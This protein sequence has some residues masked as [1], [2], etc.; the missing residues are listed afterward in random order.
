[1]NPSLTIGSTTVGHDSPCYIIG[2]IGL[3]HNGDL[4]IAK[5]LIDV[6]AFAGCDA[7]KFQKRDP[8]LCVPMDQRSVER[9]TPWGRMTY[10]EYRYKVE[11]G[12]DEFAEIDRYCKEK[13]IDWF[14]SC[15]DVNSVDFIDRFE[16][17]C[18]KLA[19]AS[20]TDDELVKKTAA[21]GRPII[22]S[23]GMSEMAE[24]EH[25]YGLLTPGQRML[26]HTVSTYPAKAS[27][28]NL[29]LIPKL[30]EQFDCPIGYSG[31][32]VGLQISLA[33]M[34]MGACCVERHITL[35][36]TMW[37]SD[38]AASVEPQGL[39]KLVRDIRVIEEARGDGIKRVYDSEVPIR[40][41]LRRV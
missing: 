21:T 24:V 16:P 31:H 8:E 34:A 35:D 9:D 30:R 33:A 13:G 5:K 12:E 37:G 23:S 25:C 6:A 32:E 7:V 28:I 20:I 15:W 22:M 41:K 11:F 29:S 38:Q 40:K 3:N 18:Y 26:L 14:A 10:F 2:E 19:S 1:M 36:R 39:I 17:V 4:D 27:E